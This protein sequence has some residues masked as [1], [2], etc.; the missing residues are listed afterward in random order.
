MR[1]IAMVGLSSLVAL[2]G[3]AMAET[4]VEVKGVHLCC[5]ACVKG[6]ATAL[7]K[8]DGVTPKC[9]KDEGTVTI[10][11]PDEAT[12]QKALDALAAAG[13]HG[14]T[15]HA[16]LAIKEETNMPAGK[17]KTLT[18]TGAHN[19]CRGCCMAIKEAVKGVK[20]V[21]GDT[22][23]PKGETFE[24]T[25]DFDAKELVKALNEAGFHAKVKE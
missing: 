4:K 22:A 24:V 20:G 8:V 25:G 10:T 17:V 11:A 9:N 3:L 7:K 6:V 13:Y 5:G 12:A 18:L 15:G 14:D 16:T 23:K 21:T 19:C 2:A 1:R